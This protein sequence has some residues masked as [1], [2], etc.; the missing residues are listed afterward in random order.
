MLGRLLQTLI[1]IGA[2][3]APFH[4]AARAA[5]PVELAPAQLRRAEQLISLFEHST[6]EIQYGAIENLHDGRGYTAGRAGFCTGTGDL[7]VVVERFLK[8][9]PGHALASFLPR[10]REL[11]EAGSDSVEGLDDLPGLWARTASEDTRFRRAQDEVA[12]ELYYL[13]ALRLAAVIGA[14]RALTIA[15]LYDASTQH[16][17]NDG[18]DGVPAL[19]ERASSLAGGAPAS[20]VDERRWLSAFLAARRADLLDP[21]NGATREVWR[22][23]VGRVDAFARLLAHG[24]LDLKGPVCVNVFGWRGCLR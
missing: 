12:R 3:G 5:D 18:P 6:P 7:V 23:S 19:I 1:V 8:R 11:A 4:T 16:G 10:L 24:D 22:E 21:A 2:I 9:V 13:P 15:E 14:R 20:G 17:P